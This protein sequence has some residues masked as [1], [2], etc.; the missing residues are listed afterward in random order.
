MDM[1]L[2]VS[3]SGW[4]LGLVFGVGLF[5]FLVLASPADAGRCS[6]DD[7]GSGR[8]TCRVVERPDYEEPED[9]P[10]KDEAGGG[11]TEEQM[12]NQYCD[13]YNI[14]YREE[15]H[16]HFYSG[17]LDGD[18]A[19]KY[20]NLDPA[21]KYMAVSA[22]C[23]YDGSHNYIDGPPG[24]FVPLAD[25]W[26]HVVEEPPDPEVL[27]EGIREQIEAAVE[28]IPVE[29]GEMAPPID[30]GVVNTT[31][32]LWV[33]NEWEPVDDEETYGSV[34]IWAEAEPVRSAYRLDGEVIA[35]CDGPGTPYT[36]GP[37][38]VG[39]NCTG[40]FEEAAID[41]REGTVEI[42]WE[43]V[44]GEWNGVDD[45]FYGPLGDPYTTSTDVTWTVD[46][47]FSTETG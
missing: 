37:L 27:V 9:G 25:R 28:A 26:I 15:F 11:M 41:G 2:R 8:K 3:Q 22:M 40:E 39:S 19:A 20:Y 12:F 23:E 47:V 33:D 35:E 36:G 44:W 16:V 32:W 42:V 38:S 17:E 30:E 29:P 13:Q 43:F 31:T 5:V 10:S 34:V 21:G 18:I 45:F 7:T 14:E 46:E 24:Y 6:Y 4:V 1:D